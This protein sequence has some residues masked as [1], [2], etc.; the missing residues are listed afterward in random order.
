MLPI[1]R[2]CVKRTV[3]VIV[4]LLVVGTV[5]IRDVGLPPDAPDTEASVRTEASAQPTSPTA[6][7]RTPDPEIPQDVAP[8]VITSITDGDTLRVDVGAHNQ[9]VR[10]LA[11]DT[12]EVPGD[13]GAAEA[14]EAL[15]ALLPAGSNVWLEADVEGRDR[16]GRLLRYV[17]RRDGLL[18]NREL[19][20]RGWA[21]A[22]LYQP[23]DRRW[24]AIRQAQVQAQAKYEGLWTRC[25]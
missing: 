20:R 10:L 5:L 14:T 11:I 22:R 8:A 4:A 23:N 18:V 16:Y 1:W 25:R 2:A 12:P 24:T 3:G 17:W 15:E 9:A 13:C 19:V 6:A 7:P 21:R